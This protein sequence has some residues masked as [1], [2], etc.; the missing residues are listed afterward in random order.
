MYIFKCKSFTVIPDIIVN[1]HAFPS[2]MTV[3]HLIEMYVG[4]CIV[5][6]PDRFGTSFDAS[7]ES[8]KIN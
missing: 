7:I 5:M 2:R 1:P 6:D 8:N 3:G 4:K